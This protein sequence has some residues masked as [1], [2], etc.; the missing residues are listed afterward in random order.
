MFLFSSALLN[1]R[2]RNF[3]D[4]DP[5]ATLA[6]INRRFMAV[7]IEEPSGLALMTKCQIASR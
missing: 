2:I 7:P 4:I 6:E 1:G 3:A 5:D